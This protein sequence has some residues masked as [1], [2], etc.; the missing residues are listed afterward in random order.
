MIFTGGVAPPLRLFPICTPAI[1]SQINHSRSE[2]WAAGR[3]DPGGAD[4]RCS[5][6]AI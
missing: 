1:Q 2:V 6:L 5:F 3:A 4:A